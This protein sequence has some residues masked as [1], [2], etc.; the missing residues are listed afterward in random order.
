[1]RLAQLSRDDGNVLGVMLFSERICQQTA[2][3]NLTGFV[4]FLHIMRDDEISGYLALLWQFSFAGVGGEFLTV[5]ASPGWRPCEEVED[6]LSDGR[7]AR[8]WRWSSDS[9]FSAPLL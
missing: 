6:G 7:H 8:L 2:T 9:F 3:A 1:M 5:R 4:T